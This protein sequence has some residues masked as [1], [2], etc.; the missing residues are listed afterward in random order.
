MLSF[1]R[2]CSYFST[3]KRNNF[4]HAVEYYNEFSAVLEAPLARKPGG[5][6]LLCKNAHRLNKR[7][8]MLYL[9]REFHVAIDKFKFLTYSDSRITRNK[10]NRTLK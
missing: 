7:V 8:K 4:P 6:L 5:T 3:V 2:S 10:H 9:I 1:T